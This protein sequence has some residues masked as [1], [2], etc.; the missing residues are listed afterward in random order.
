MTDI[1]NI[2]FDGLKK[3]MLAKFSDLKENSI[4]SEHMNSPPVFPCIMAYESSNSTLEATADERG[5]H[6]ANLRYTI[7][8]YTNNKN[9]KKQK[10]KELANAIDA[11][12]LDLGFLRASKQYTI[13]AN[14][15]TTFVVTCSYRCV[16]GE[17]YA[18]DD[19]TIMIYRR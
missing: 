15:A 7:E 4:R 8:V 17:S 3:H 12:M 9:G 1:E 16:A 2:V 14:E 13:G 11:Y 19:N 5:E 10:A 18:G 6:H